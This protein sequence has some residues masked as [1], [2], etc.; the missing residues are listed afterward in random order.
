MTVEGPGLKGS[1]KENDALHHEES[2]GEA[3]GESAARFTAENPSILEMSV[4]WDDP[5]EQQ[6]QWNGASR[7]LEDRPCMLQRAELEKSP[8]FFTGIE[9]L[10][11][12]FK[13]IK[14]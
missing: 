8:N 14:R 9:K 13:I 7:S 11:R 6:Q 3:V 5:Q 1:C 12:K 2:L 10:V 4:T